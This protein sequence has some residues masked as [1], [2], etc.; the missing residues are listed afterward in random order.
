M[1]SLPLLHDECVA[2]GRVG[3]WYAISVREDGVA[4]HFY[5]GFETTATLGGV[6]VALRETSDYP[7][8]GEVRIEIDP[9]APVA[10]DL[11]LRIPGWAKKASAAVNGEPIALAPVNGCQR[12]SK[13]ASL[14]GAKM[15]Q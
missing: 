13:I 3:G 1:A 7:W 15:H 5:G 10:F 6:E 12:R 14:A 8:V 9:E 11:K 4:F 2:P